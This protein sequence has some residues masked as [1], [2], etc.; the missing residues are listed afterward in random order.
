VAPAGYAALAAELPALRAAGVPF[1]DLT[2]VFADVA[3]TVYVDDCCHVNRLGNE[4]L[5]R[6][7]GAAVL[8][9]L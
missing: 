5:A 4:L 6:A 9:G 8:A 2:R 1:T 3:E 7:I